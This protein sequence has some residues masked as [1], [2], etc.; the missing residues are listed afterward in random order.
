MDST[1]VQRRGSV[2]TWASPSAPGPRGWAHNATNVR[3]LA[4]ASP[5]TAVLLRLAAADQFAFG[6][7][8]PAAARTMASSQQSKDYYEILGVARD[9]TR[10]QITKAYRDLARRLHPDKN[11]SPDA[12]DQFIRVKQAYETLADPRKRQLYDRLGERGAAMADM[13]FSNVSYAD[14]TQS[15]AAMSAIACVL[16]TLALVCGVFPVLLCLRMDGIITWSWW[17]VLLPLWLLLVPLLLI[18]VLLGILPQLPAIRDPNVLDD[19]RVKLRAGVGS[20]G[21][22]AL[23]LLGVLVTTVLLVLKADGA[24]SFSYQVALAPFAVAQVLELLVFSYYL[25]D[26]HAVRYGGDTQDTHDHPA[27]RGLGAQ[28]F[29]H[30]LTVAQREVALAAF[31]VLLA[32]KLDGQLPTATYWDVFTPLFATCAYALLMAVSVRSC[33]PPTARRSRPPTPRRR[34]TACAPT[35][36]TALSCL[37]T[38]SPKSALA[39]LARAAARLFSR[40]CWSCCATRQ[41]SSGARCPRL[42]RCPPSWQ[43]CVP[44]CPNPMP[45]FC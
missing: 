3:P 1:A 43:W 26:I 24:A 32:L 8:R 31:A 18:V 2:C 42:W 19:V 13:D 38:P 6:H 9:A 34:L 44:S 11:P 10:E 4:L 30:W 16:C 23:S 39:S 15:F 29:V 41:P 25:G 5:V 22:V 21:K 27:P 45:I 14:L 7:R 28:K 17:V 12:H 37:A 36:P 40:A 33:C 20:A 35:T